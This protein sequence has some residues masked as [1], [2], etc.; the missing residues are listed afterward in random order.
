VSVV[1]IG[2]SHRT[3]PV[4]LLERMAVPPA[5]LT[6]ALHTLQRSENLAEVAV[7]STCNR[8]EVYA[9][10]TRF[11]PAVE[12]VR[13][14]LTDLAGSD[15]DVFAD[16]LYTYHDDAAITHLFGV[17]AGLDSM[18]VGEGEILGQVREAWLA[19]EREGTVGQ[20]LSTALRQAVEVG[21][22]SRTET[23]IGRHAVSVSSA[24]V[25]VAAERLNGL[26]GRRVL[27]IGAGDV[28]EGMAV[29]LS[30]AGVQE[31]V[32]ANRTPERAEALAARIGG[33]AI[34]LEDVHDHISEAD[35]LL[36]STGAAD[37]L[38]ER[39]DIETAMTRR[40]GRA[41]LI[42]DVAVPRNIDPGVAQVFGVTLLDIDDLKAFA[43]QSLEHR[44]QEIGRV[45]DIINEELDR[46]REERSAR[47]VAPLIAA[48]RRRAEQLRQAELERHRSRLAALDPAARATVEAVTRGL[49]NKLLHD[50]TVGVK[51]A[52]GSVRGELYAD[53]LAEL[54]DLD[55]VL[56]LVERPTDEG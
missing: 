49:V 17:A 35:L 20:S 7:L 32:V 27:V 5:G 31:I 52:A 22:R 56:G 18:I 3:T 41:L 38:V 24:A 43:A 1:V 50:P 12:E 16:H 23:A 26:E 13:N 25:A 33:R 53:A 8:T 11:H 6:K 40:D 55:E 28:G 19:A 37:V 4:E 10:C 30:G 47:E 48:L 21:K 29:A 15:P 34:A 54:F 45:R 39:G 42:V 2:L 51:R 36:A 44:R 14:F 46:F 9:R